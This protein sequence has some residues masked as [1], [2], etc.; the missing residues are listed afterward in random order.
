MQLPNLPAVT[1][2][3]HQ[4]YEETELFKL[5]QVVTKEWFGTH[6]KVKYKDA[7]L[8][9]GTLCHIAMYYAISF[10]TAY[11]WL[12]SN[13]S[14]YNNCFTPGQPEFVVQKELHMLKNL[15]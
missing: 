11:T 14:M 12:M 1:Y 7:E 5:S 3:V 6:Q 10:G 2:N 15:D 9:C 13:P 8:K 4:K